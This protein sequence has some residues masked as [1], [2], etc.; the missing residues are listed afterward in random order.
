MSP[1]TAAPLPRHPLIELWSRY[2][3]VFKAAWER[4]AE[5]A[6]P[7][8]LADETAFLP[9][10]LSLQETPVHPAPRRFAWAIMAL[11]VLVLV[12]SIFGKVD[13][14]A[15]AP[16]R[17]IVS[18]RTKLIQPLEASVVKR[19]LV[20]DGDR[21]RAGQVLVELDPTMA[22]ADKA[23]VQEQLNAAISEEQRTAALL[24]TLATGQAP[25]LPKGADAG[26]RSLLQSEWQ[27]IRAK[28]AKLDA[29]A[30]RRQAEMATVQATIAK[31]EDT[32]P[33]AQAR[34]ADFKRLV[35]QGYISGHATQDKTRERVELERDL[36]TQRA[37][38]AEAQAMLRESEQSRAAFRAETVRQLNDRNAQATTKRQQ[39]SADHSKASQRER[40]TQL[41][42][43]VDGIVQ[44]LA[45]HSVGGVVTSAQPLMI[46]V[47]DSPTVTA[48]IA[49]ANQDIGFVNAG[50]TATVKLETFPYTRYGT[51]DAKVE[52]VTAD[53]VT[54]EKKGSYYPAILTLSQKD[55]D[56]DGK[57]I[58]L[59]PGMNITAEIKT[60]K[61]RVIEY[62]LSPVQRAG[63]ESLRER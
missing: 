6:G 20:R 15:V 30:S 28:L 54:D 14:V 2:R 57:R 35:D 51:V 55:M 18:D 13:I 58:P 9:A 63:N 7:K 4:R 34:E 59:S 39:L 38:L 56:I 24:N 50:Q 42:A 43:P 8:R 19:V 41:T 37:R 33:M 48:E 46:V 36:A 47:P 11:F 44:Q 16:G 17:I 62:L 12:W 5:L 27:D 61:R 53:A 22:N 26:T 45:I 40:L 1:N 31:L 3:A 32:V 25:S 23:S 10:A 52:V 29:E 21:V 60:G 49:I